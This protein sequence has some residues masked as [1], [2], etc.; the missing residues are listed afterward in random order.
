MTNKEIIFETIQMEGKLELVESYL[1]NEL[2]TFAEWKRR[3]YKVNKGEKAV[4]KAALWKKGE[5]KK[6]DKKNEEKKESYFFTKVSALFTKNQVS[7]I[8]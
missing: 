6:K 1:N 8:K 3:G 5:K 4:L 2:L 7:K